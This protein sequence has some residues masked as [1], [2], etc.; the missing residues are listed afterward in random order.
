MYLW[1]GLEYLLLSP[2]KEYLR[3]S[4]MSFKAINGWCEKIE[5]AV[6]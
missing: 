1:G 5:S 4:T 2:A 3:N 6:G